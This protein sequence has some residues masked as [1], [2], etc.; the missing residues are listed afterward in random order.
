MSTSTGTSRVQPSAFGCITAPFLLVAILIMVWGGRSNWQRGQLGRDGVAVVGEVI[1]LRREPGNPTVRSEKASSAS[2]VVRFT[3]EDG[4]TRTAVSST[5]RAPIP[6]E[7]GEEVEVVYD[8]TNPDRADLRSET[9]N[10]VLWF[11][12]WCVVAGVF[13]GIAAIPVVMKLREAPSGA[14]SSS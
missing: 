9:D 13:A 10:W 5:N 12:I 6:W 8:R 14:T 7:V 11:V 3:T 2:A 1:E 4:Q